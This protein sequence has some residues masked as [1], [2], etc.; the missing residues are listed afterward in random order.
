MLFSGLVNIIQGLTFLKK[1]KETKKEGDESEGPEM[2]AEKQQKTQYA[3][4][5]E[6]E[7]TIDE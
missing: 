4:I 2:D 6:G 5:N 3:A 1:Y 7:E